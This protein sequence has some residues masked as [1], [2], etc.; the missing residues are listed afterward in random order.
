MGLGG[1][2][3]SDQFFVPGYVLFDPEFKKSLADSGLPE[4][5]KKRPAVPGQEQSS[6]RLRS[7]WSI[8]KNLFVKFS[9][10]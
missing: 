3:L 1:L 8:H 5:F 2:T 9:N 4:E 6:R 7:S 10:A